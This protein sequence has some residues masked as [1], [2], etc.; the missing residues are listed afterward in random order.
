MH[1]II[2][3][4]NVSTDAVFLSE[5]NKLG[6]AFNPPKKQKAHEWAFCFALLSCRCAILIKFI[7]KGSKLPF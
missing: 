3:A 1:I 5:A 7:N 4:L 6:T 2:T